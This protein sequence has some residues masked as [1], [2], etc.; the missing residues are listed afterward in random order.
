MPIE[1][2][3]VATDLSERE[4]GA[5]L[6]AQQLA[7]AHNATLHVH[8]LPLKAKALK[9]LAARTRGVDLVV[10]PHRHE[11]SLAAL[12]RGQLLMRLLRECDRPILM[13]RT[14]AVTPYRRIVIPVDFSPHSATLVGLA[15]DLAQDAELRVIHA[16]S[17]RD[18][19][20][21]KSA[22]VM[23]P[24]VRA[25]RERSRH[26]A[27]GR[28]LQLRTELVAHGNRLFTKIGSGDPARQAVSDVER[29]AASQRREAQRVEAPSCDFADKPRLAV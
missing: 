27:Q 1:S 15:A 8:A 18:E 20:R 5:V 26:H 6:R 17:T 22:G 19:S 9:E 2:I 25:Y 13:A 21:L 7:G 14:A 16:I 24:V 28:M 23:E 3:L 11:R 4:N 12:F 10:L 29:S